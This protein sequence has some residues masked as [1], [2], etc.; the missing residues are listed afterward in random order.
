LAFAGHE[1]C[2]VAADGFVGGFLFQVDLLGF[3][4]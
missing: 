4:D 2:A 1:F 3:S